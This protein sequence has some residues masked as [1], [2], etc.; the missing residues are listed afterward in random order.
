MSRIAQSTIQ[1]VERKLDALAVVED[2]VR[3]EKRGG[4]YWGRCPFHS[5]GQERTPSFTVDPDK[6]MYY[7][8]GCREGGSIIK[9]IMEMDKLSF[10]E[11]VETLARRFGIEIIR[12]NGAVE[13]T[14][15]EKKSRL[16]GLIELYRGVS[17]S[18]H[19][20]FMKK[21]EGSAAK[22]YIISRGISREMMERFRLGYSP[23]DRSWLYGFLTKKGFSPPLLAA[24]GLFSDRYPQSSFFSNRL[25]FPIADRQG[26]T[27]A[28]GGRIL[29]G[30]GPKYINSRETEI[31]HKGQT[32]FAID[33][34][35]P[36]IR[37][38]KTAYLAEGYMDAIALHQAGILNALA[39]LGTA[40]TDEQAKL[41]ARWAG[42]INLVFDSDEAGQNAAVK[43]ILTCRKNGL[44][45]AVVVPDRNQGEGEDNFKDPADIL[46]YQGPDAL[47]KQM[48]C[49]ILDF[50]YLVSR[51]KRLFDISRSE[52]KAK[53]AAFLF[54]YLELLDSEIS[55]DACF[56]AVADALGAD[57]TAIL[58]DYNRRFTGKK[59]PPPEGEGPPQM[60][61]ELGLLTLVL[62]NFGLYPEFRR[63]VRVEEIEDT[64]AR[65]L[66]IAMEE[67]YVR[68]ESGAD[69]IL[70]RISS[71]PLRNYVVGKGVSR[72]FSGNPGQ[73]MKDGI[74]R[75]NQKR[76]RRRLSDIAAE[77]HGLEHNPAA[78]G[79]QDRLDELLAEKIHIDT[80]LRHLKE[81]KVWP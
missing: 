42:Q 71:V 58:N 15:P 70:S 80:E 52:G 56:G 24:S 49:L 61:D 60:N 40:F 21:P 45:C 63:I 18:F 23:A 32:L 2:Y 73:L 13:D 43:A 10:P 1:E 59:P 55:R 28:F 65:E 78:Q 4:R 11:A 37:K 62:V 7:C 25:M 31:Y 54:P 20:F 76:L 35:L 53:A 5:G 41:L 64:A 14:D 16:E 17:V 57:R 3:L 68:D 69:A 38:T 79:R 39:P 66:F 33:L 51:S 48:Q 8:F 9:F 47:H 19:Y 30:E 6:K 27:V 81:D 74:N 26:R 36:E 29:A 34:A 22:E 44:A 50:E 72:E 46:K 12:E 75:L 77:L 67:C